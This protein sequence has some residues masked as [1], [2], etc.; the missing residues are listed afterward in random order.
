MSL[1]VAKAM[2]LNYRLEFTAVG[3]DRKLR[4]Y[5]LFVP[6]E[7]IG[8]TIIP[9]LSTVDALPVEAKFASKRRTRRLLPLEVRP[10]SNKATIA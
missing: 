7:L 5:D 3:F 2:A 10:T 6:E 4:C 1:S 9:Y 8:T